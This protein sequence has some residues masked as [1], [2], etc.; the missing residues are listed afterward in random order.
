MM[1]PGTAV[2]AQTVLMVLANPQ[3]Q[4]QVLNAAWQVKEAEAQYNGLQVAALGQCTSHI[5]VGI[6]LTSISAIRVRR[7]AANL[8]IPS[9]RPLGT[10]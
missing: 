8:F 7:S 3:L 10:T 9:A 2:K 1:F 4:Q 5:F 6:C